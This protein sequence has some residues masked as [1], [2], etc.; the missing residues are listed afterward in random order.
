MLRRHITLIAILL[1]SALASA[2]ASSAAAQTEAGSAARSVAGTYRYKTYQPGKAGYDNLLEITEG[3]GGGLRISLSGT[4]IYP[5]NGAET[6]KE[7][8]GEGAAT[9]RGAVATAEVLPDGGD[10]PC[11]V[12]ITFAGGKAEVKTDED[13]GFNVVLDGAYTKEAAAAVAP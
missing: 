9:L 11:R 6:M 4:Y 13:C 3:E 8:S 2:G 1:T 5:A 10:T 7:A 12:E